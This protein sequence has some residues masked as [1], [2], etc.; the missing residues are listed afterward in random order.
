MGTQQIL[1]IA[2]SM[3]VIGL[4]VTLGISMFTRQAFDANR[5]AVAAE[6]Q[7]LSTGVIQY[8][9]TPVGMGGAGQNIAFASSDSLGVNLG[10]VYESAK[11]PGQ[12]AYWGMI[13]DNGEFRMLGIDNSVVTF[14]AL[15]VET[16]NNLHPRVET[17]INLISGLIRTTFSEA[18]SF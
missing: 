11:G 9:K 10:F 16:K 6:M 7:Q 17:K 1:L 18:E 15:G 8:W 2:I 13:S 12:S 5:Q 3:I 4:A 14:Q